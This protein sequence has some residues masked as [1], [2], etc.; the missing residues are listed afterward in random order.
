MSYSDLWRSLVPQ[1]GS[2]DF[3]NVTDEWPCLW[4]EYFLNI[5]HNVHQACSLVGKRSKHRKVWKLMAEQNYTLLREVCLN[6]PYLL[7]HGL[8]YTKNSPLLHHLP[9]KSWFTIGLAMWYLCNCVVVKEQ[10][11]VIHMYVYNG[12]HWKLIL[13]AINR[14][15][16]VPFKYQLCIFFD[17]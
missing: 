6:M 8:E 16:N 15:I 9:Q 2:Y 14:S 10:Y 17:I 12:S 3:T 11:I 7:E 1:T 5:G 13:V 4:E